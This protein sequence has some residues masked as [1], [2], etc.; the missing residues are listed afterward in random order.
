M[1]TLDALLAYLATRA[2]PGVLSTQSYD[3][4][5]VVVVVSY[6]DP[7]GGLT[8]RSRP[9]DRPKDADQVRRHVIARARA[10]GARLVA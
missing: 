10:A 7:D 2:E 9:Y 5:G 6:A 3:E 4:G 8:W 1:P